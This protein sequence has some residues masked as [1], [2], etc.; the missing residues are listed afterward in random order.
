[1][2]L[3]LGASGCT[4]SYLLDELLDQ[5]DETVIAWVRH[6]ERLRR[7]ADARLRIWDGGLEALDRYRSELAGV[8]AL[9]HT[10]TAWGGPQTFDVNYRRSWDL[11]QTLAAAGCR[12]MHLLSTASLLDGTH[13]PWRQAHQL[14]TDYIRSKAA[15]HQRLIQAR[16]PV[17]V[18]Y[19][20]VI[21][22]GDADH[23]ATAVSAALPD[24][25]RWLPWLRWLRAQGWVHLIHA[26]DIAR[27]VVW[28]LRRQLP[29]EQLVLGNPAL[30]VREVLETLNRVYGQ[31][32]APLR[33]PLEPLLPLLLPLLQAQMS[34]WDR[35]SLFQRHL[36]YASVHAAAYGLPTDLMALAAMLP[37]PQKNQ[38]ARG[39][40]V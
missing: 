31:A 21:L 3:L 19:P 23:P 10:A 25:T 8:T 15:L 4:G 36:H 28:R 18:Y 26:R 17:S 37:E 40:A 2:I 27:I 30:S 1:M 33:L 12:E 24:L 34:P 22:G 7:P 32:P 35:F 11:L 39:P 6:R 20:T 38:P 13:R 16:L 29:P 14:G 5:T 9:I